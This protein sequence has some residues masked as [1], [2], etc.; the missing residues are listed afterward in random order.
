M[1]TAG[2]LDRIREILFGDI[3]TELEQRLARA[4]HHVTTRTQELKEDARRRT[5]VLEAHMRKEAEAS[6][7]RAARQLGELT[8]SIRSLRNEHRDALAAIEQRLSRIEDRIEASIARVER[9]AREQLLE[10]AKL[11]LDQLEQTR[12]Q[13]QATLARELGL[14]AAQGT[15]SEPDT[16]SAP[17]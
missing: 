15:E 16:W 7:S 5:D 2:G 11:F 6:S 3:L 10:Q 17:H 4:D 8:E 13:L 1:A 9:E 14:D 12:Q